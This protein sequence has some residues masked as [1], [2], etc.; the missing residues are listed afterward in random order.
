MRTGW[1]KIA[2]RSRGHDL[3][4]KTKP[5]HVA[6]EGVTKSFDE[7]VALDDA[8]LDVAPGEFVTIL[9]ESGSGKTTTL[10]IIAGFEAPTRGEIRLDGRSITR[11]PAYQRNFGMV[12][13]NY[14]LFPHL[15][16][17]ENVAFPLRRRHLPNREIRQRVAS[18]LELVHLSGLER[19][20]PHEL[21]GGQQQRVALA[22]ATVY[23]P[24]VLLMDEPLSALDKKLRQNMQRELRHIHRNLGTTI[25]YVTHDQEEALALS[26]K[27]ALMRAGRIEQ[28]GTPAEIYERPRS[29]FAASFLGEANLLFGQVIDSAPAGVVSIRLHNGQLAEATSSSAVTAGSE[30]V[31]VVRPESLLL[32]DDER[33]AVRITVTEA[34]YLGS[35]VRCMGEFETGERCVLA[36]DVATG[37]DLVRRGRGCVRWEPRSAVVLDSGEVGAQA[38]EPPVVDEPQPAAHLDVDDR[39]NAAIAP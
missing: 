23:S 12:F 37:T 29:L 13:Q 3:M 38:L 32:S 18:A 4:G 16:V 1:T 33:R 6:L 22:R 20:Y 34:V 5:G 26:D 7:V 24:P 36:L 8:S 35:S 27:I 10:L 39:A 9:G 14:A 30:K 21:S 25:V 31:V 2:S 19:R 28:V 11:V 15:R 17:F